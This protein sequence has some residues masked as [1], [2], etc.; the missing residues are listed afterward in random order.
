MK[1]LIPFVAVLMLLAG[2]AQA[3]VTGTGAPAASPL[4]PEE[5]EDSSTFSP[6]PEQ[7][8]ETETTPLPTPA[9]TPAATPV[10]TSPT[11]APEPSPEESPQPEEE[12]PDDETVL[13]CYR[14]AV[15]AYRWF[16]AESMPY[17]PADSRTEGD[18][19]Y[20]RVDYPGIAALSDL[21]GYLKSLFSDELVDQL[22]PAAGRQYVDLDGILYVSPGARGDDL[23]K[24]AE[25]RQVL[26]DGAERRLVQVTVEQLDPEQD[27]AVVGS[28]TYEFPYEKVGETWIFT[29]FSLVR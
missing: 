22:L 1:R 23:T 26:R 25:T 8:P 12:G 2:C 9:P 7:T 21:R 6:A 19:V 18:V 13:A 24:G 10:P 27:F 11:A 15:E 29:D 28:E 17:D 3:G 16:Q 4:A 5:T 14:R 20:Y